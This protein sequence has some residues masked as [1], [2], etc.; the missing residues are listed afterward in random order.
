MA[1]DYEDSINEL[2]ETVETTVPPKKARVSDCEEV[3]ASFMCAI[4]RRERSAS[5]KNDRGKQ[6]QMRPVYAEIRF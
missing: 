3:A 4:L 5:F 2:Q 6:H 1:D